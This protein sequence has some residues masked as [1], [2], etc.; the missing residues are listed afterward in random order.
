MPEPVFLTMKSFLSQFVD[1][2]DLAFVA[3][4]ME[5]R[6]RA[7]VAVENERCI[8]AIF[9]DYRIPGEFQIKATAAIR[10]APE[11]SVEE[12]MKDD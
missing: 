6:E 12:E 11:P 2:E 10:R 9:D 5:D 4:W 1:D 7:A 3:A 8:E